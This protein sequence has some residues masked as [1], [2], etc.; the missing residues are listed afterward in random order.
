VLNEPPRPEDLPEQQ[1]EPYAALPPELVSAP[2]HA[3]RAAPSVQQPAS[4]AASKRLRL[5][6]IASVVVLALVAAIALVVVRLAGRDDP[7]AGSATPSSATAAPSPSPTATASPVPTSTDHPK[8]LDRFYT[9]SVSWKPCADSK[10]QQCGTAIVPVDYAKPGGD[11]FAL[12]LRKAPALDPSKKVGSL[13]INPGGP[14]ASGVQYAQYATFVFS[15]DLRTAYDIVGF[16]PRGVAASGAVGCLTDRDLDG[17]FAVDPTPDTAAERTRLISTWEGAAESCAARG[18]E[19][20]LHM[21][22]V[23]VARDLDILRALVGDPQL[24]YFGVSYGTFLGALYADLFPQR[25]GR[26]VLDSAVSPNQTEL[27]QL[28]YDVQGFESSM[29][30]FVDWCVAQDSCALGTDKDRAADVVA[31]LLDRIDSRPLKTNKAGLPAVGEGWV[32]FAIFMCL[33]SEETWPT[34][35]KGLTEALTK[36][37]ADILVS[38]AFSVVDRSSNG[39]YAKSTYLQAMV[40]VRCA[41][42]PR[43]P[44]TAAYR[45]QLGKLRSAHPLWAKLSG[46]PFDNCRTW[47]GTPR[48]AKGSTLG[49]G[50]A[51]ILVI[52][53]L[54]DPATPIGG[55]E[56]LAA[57]LDSGRLV[58]VDSD[59]H[60]AYYS[61]NTCIDSVVDGYLV[62]GSVPKDGKTC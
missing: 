36:D 57:D 9:Q 39:G 50:A 10:K 47:P 24:N 12:A 48:A 26:F 41:D 31:E 23:E 13:L 14:G 32:G 45:A 16:D 8:A 42:W 34:L 53:N 5:A 62:K 11:T 29:A 38:L 27:Q 59:G 17:L 61:G 30:A 40:P 4:T 46:E 56:Q 22:S 28:T 18:G 55:T 58:T 35:N 21:S 33:Y 54:R 43:T 6:V 19:R 44:D 60:G 37:R 25:V 2:T 15:K 3:E 20:A 51:P 1:G 52:G 49:V 7:R